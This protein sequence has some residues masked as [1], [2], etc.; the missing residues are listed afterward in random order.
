MAACAGN[1]VESAWPAVVEL[2]MSRAGRLTSSPAAELDA[3][4]AELSSADEMRLELESVGIAVLCTAACFG[5][6]R[7]KQ[8]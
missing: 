1:L 8:S 5:H 3:E 6:K 4:E 2:D 7:P